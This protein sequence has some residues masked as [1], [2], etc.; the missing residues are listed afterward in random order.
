MKPDARGL[1]E[2]DDPHPPFARLIPLQEVIAA[3]RGVGVN[4]RRVMREYDAVIDQVGSELA[5]LLYAS[6]SD[7]L[8]VAGET[9]TEAIVRARTG[10]V[11]VEPGYDGIYGT[12]KPVSEPLAASQ[13]T[14]L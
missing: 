14:L 7:L 8:P 11:T 5:A 6:E 1:I 3:V 12:V 4:T 9:L 13:P 10:E 2:S